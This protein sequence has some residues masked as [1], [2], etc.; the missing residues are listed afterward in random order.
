[1]S[2]FVERGRHDVGQGVGVWV[3]QGKAVVVKHLASL[4]LIPNTLLVIWLL[5]MLAFKERR[6]HP[7]CVIALPGSYCSHDK[8]VN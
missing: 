5:R 3:G 4:S 7:V 2:C 6:L 1:M 8:L